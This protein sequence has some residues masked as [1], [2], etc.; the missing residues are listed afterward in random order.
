MVVSLRTTTSS[1]GVYSVRVDYCVVIDSHL[2]VEFLDS[3]PY[4]KYRHCRRSPHPIQ[5]MGRMGMAIL[6]QDSLF[7]L[8][9]QHCSGPCLDSFVGLSGPLALTP[10]ATGQV[11]TCDQDV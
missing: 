8:V 10:L 7:F 1:D 3:L 11:E 4:W 9:A 6:L 2:S 5:T